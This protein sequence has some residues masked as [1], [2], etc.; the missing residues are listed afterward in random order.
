MHSVIAS[1]IVNNNE[2]KPTTGPHEN[3]DLMR[4]IIFG[5]G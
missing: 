1:I 2:N 3:E 5:T 4:A